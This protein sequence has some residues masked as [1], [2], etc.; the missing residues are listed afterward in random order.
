MPQPTIASYDHALTARVQGGLIRLPDV[1]RLTS[2]SRSWIYREMRHGRFPSQAELP[3]T[4][5]AVW[6][7]ADVMGWLATL[8]VDTLDGE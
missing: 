7:R 4:T 2:M 5:T 8:A 3:G 1:M 6:W